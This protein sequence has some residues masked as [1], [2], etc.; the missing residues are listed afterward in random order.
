MKNRILLALILSLSILPSYSQKK[1]T[2]PQ[3][4]E[5][6]YKFT[7]V[8]ELKATPVKNQ[9]STG[10]CWNFATTSFIESELIRKGKGEYD[11]SEMYIIRCTMLTGSRI[12]LS[13]REK[14]TS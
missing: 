14:E 6:G 4:T 12:T 7:P 5:E 9:A 8:V 11:L 13:K 2:S 10:T 3:K 1:N